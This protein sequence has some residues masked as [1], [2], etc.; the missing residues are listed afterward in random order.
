MMTDANIALHGANA[1]LTKNGRSLE[2]RIPSPQGASFSTVSAHREKPENPNTGYQQLVLEHVERT[3][4]TR[5]AVRLSTKAM[6]GSIR[7][8]TEWRGPNIEL[9]ISLLSADSVQT[10]VDH[11]FGDHSATDSFPNS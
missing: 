5:I 11:G 10:A 6:P 1:I 9:I 2:A 8:L 7:P 3:A 4:E